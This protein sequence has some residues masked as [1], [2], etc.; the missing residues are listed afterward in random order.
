MPVIVS[1]LRALILRQGWFSGGSSAVFGVVGLWL[2]QSLA[3]LGD[4]LSLAPHAP[5]ECLMHS[6]CQWNKSLPGWQ[7]VGVLRTLVRGV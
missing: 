4:V 7:R 6:Q 5:G 3:L 1:D 2:S